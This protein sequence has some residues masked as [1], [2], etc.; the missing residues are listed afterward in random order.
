MI[1]KFKTGTRLKFV[2]LTIKISL[3]ENLVMVGSVTTCRGRGHIVAA[4]RLQAAQ[5]VS[6]LN[7]FTRVRC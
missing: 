1:V 2:V 7:I 4:P 3:H 6:F 5:I